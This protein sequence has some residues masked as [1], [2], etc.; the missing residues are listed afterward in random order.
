MR[1]RTV[2]DASMV[3]AKLTA[4]SAGDVKLELPPIETPKGFTPLGKVGHAG[5]VAST[6]APSTTRFASM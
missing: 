3:S 6:S 5:N 1:P 2:P 4:P